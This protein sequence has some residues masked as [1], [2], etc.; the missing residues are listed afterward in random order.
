M[1]GT[2]LRV[3][4]LRKNWTQAQTAEE[5]RIGVTTLQNWEL[6]KGEPCLANLRRIEE[7]FDLTAEDLGI[8]YE[9]TAP[10]RSIERLDTPQLQSFTSQ[11]LEMRLAMLASQTFRSYRHVQNAMAQ[12]LKDSIMNTESHHI[13]RREAL[14]RL[15]AF[16]AAT[17]LLQGDIAQPAQY[18][19]LLAQCPASIEACWQLYEGEGRDRRLALECVSKYLVALKGI[20]KDSPKYRKKAAELAARCATIKSILGWHYLGY[21]ESITAAHEAVEYARLAGNFSLQLS[22][23]SKLSWS[24]LYDKKFGNALTAAQEAKFILEQTKVPLPGCITGGI[25]STLALMQARNRQSADDALGICFDIDP[26]DEYIDFMQFSRIDFPGEAGL[27]YVY[28]GNSKAAL[29]LLSDIIDPDT[30]E[31]KRPERYGRMQVYHT[32]ILAML[33]SKDRD[34][35]KVIQLWLTAITKA[36]SLQS[37]QGFDDALQSYE[38][39]KIVWPGETRI[40]ELQN[41]LV[42]W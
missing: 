9:D 29:Q 25:Y 4:R 8:V 20:I 10:D 40:E 11:D 3:A 18:S 35:D 13:N 34:M 36:K 14:T 27:T 28:Q 32:M 26:G 2:K 5:L 1:D 42:R 19:A 33:R 6:S 39:M 23:Y 7:V 17:L 16:P 21:P 31:D 37:E 15:A 30:L 24:Y 38:L 22:A 12:I 41:H